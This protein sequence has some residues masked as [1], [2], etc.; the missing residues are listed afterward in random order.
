MVIL[1]QPQKDTNWSRWMQ[2]LYIKYT[3][4]AYENTDF[5]FF[6]SGPHV[7]TSLKA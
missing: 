4:I 2:T 7:L 5:E 1:G 6:V 3:K